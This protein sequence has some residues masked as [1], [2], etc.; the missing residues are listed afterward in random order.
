METVALL[1]EAAVS[2]VD[3]ELSTFG[4]RWGGG[5]AGVGGAG[6]NLLADPALGGGLPPG[7]AGLSGIAVT[8]AAGGTGGPVPVCICLDDGEES[9][10]APAANGTMDDG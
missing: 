9:A 10:A 8:A 2:L 1:P 7:G 5:S 4:T 6:D 3:S